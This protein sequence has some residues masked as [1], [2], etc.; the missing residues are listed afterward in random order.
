MKKL[1]QLFKQIL[2]SKCLTKGEKIYLRKTFKDFVNRRKIIARNS[3]QLIDE[4][5]FW[6]EVQLDWPGSK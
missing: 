1:K 4:S 2:E 3:V 6:P 5:D